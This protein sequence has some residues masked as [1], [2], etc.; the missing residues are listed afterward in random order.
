M[1]LDRSLSVSDPLGYLDT[2]KNRSQNHPDVYDEVLEIMDR[3][4]KNHKCVPSVTV[5]ER[6][7]RLTFKGRHHF[8]ARQRYSPPTRL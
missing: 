8:I 6:L 3:V 5:S 7:T 1:G 2:V 4:Q